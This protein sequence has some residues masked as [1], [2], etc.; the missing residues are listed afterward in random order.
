M[1]KIKN[2]SGVAPPTEESKAL[3]NCVLALKGKDVLELGTGTG[4]VAIGASQKGRKVL[5]TDINHKAVEACKTNAQLNNI[6]LMILQ[7]DLFKNVSGKFDI[8]AFNPPISIDKASSDTTHRIKSFIRST[9]LLRSVLRY[10]YSKLNKSVLRL[11]DKLFIDAKE[12]LKENGGIL[13]CVIN[14][15]EE[16]I[17]NLSDKRGYNHEVMSNFGYGKVYRFTLR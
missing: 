11:I 1:I 2:F 7:S 17:N 14:N 15:F 12:Y 6:N 9:K 16:D 13:I 5:A 3:L 8:I 10:T 4:Y